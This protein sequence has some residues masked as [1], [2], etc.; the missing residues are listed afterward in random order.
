MSTGS[1]KTYLSFLLFLYVSGGYVSRKTLSSELGLGEGVVRSHLRFLNER[2]LV[3]SVRA[4]NALTDSG[5]NGVRGLLEAVSAKR[6]G[7]APA[8]ELN[9]R[10]AVYVLLHGYPPAENVVKLRDEA[11]REGAD[12]AVIA[13]FDGGKF[14]LPP[15]GED[16]CSYAPRLCGEVLGEAEEEDCL[17]VVFGERLGAAVKGLVGILLSEKAPW[18]PSLLESLELLLRS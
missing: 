2:G 4:G 14:R 17:L 9:A 15:G 11:V 7:L 16:L 3:R 18:R 8:W 1:S 6:L 12:G 10:E 13:V 5:R